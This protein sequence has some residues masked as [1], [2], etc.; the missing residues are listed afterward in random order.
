MDIGAIAFIDCLGF[1]GIWQ[2]YSPEAVLEQLM[3]AEKKGREM[4]NAFAQIVGPSSMK[5]AC[6]SLSDTIVVSVTHAQPT[7]VSEAVKGMLVGCAGI[8]GQQLAKHLIRAQHPIALRGCVTF[9][10][11]LVTDRHIIGPA[12]DEAATLH[13]RANGA[14]IWLH[15]DLRAPLHAFW[16]N[17]VD[18]FSAAPVE[19]I[20]VFANKAAFALGSQTHQEQLGS[21][22]RLR[23]AL[24]HRGLHDFMDYDMPL[25]SGD[26][27]WCPVVNPLAGAPDSEFM[28]RQYVS[29]MTAPAMDVIV[30]RQNTMRFLQVAAGHSHA[31]SAQLAKIMHG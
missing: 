28:L 16:K 26:R 21:A 11:F 31:V 23:K 3:S 19:D 27:L 9:G 13:E 12:I 17:V 1:K 25:K 7:D 24:L 14:F 29:A 20:L 10:R 6:V 22:E 5:F 2:K 30:K 18:R 8:V 4:A 15:P